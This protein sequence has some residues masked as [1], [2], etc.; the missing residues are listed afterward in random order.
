MTAAS[1]AAERAARDSYG[2]LLAWLAARG[3]DIAAAEDALAD[4]FAAALATWPRDG[5]PDKPEA[6]LLTA[7]RR[8]LLDGHRRR[9]TAT[10]AEPTLRHTAL[11]AEEA[12]AEAIPDH[13]L[14]LLL[15]CAAPEVERAAQA[16]LMLQVVL[17]LD[18]ARI[19]SAF[20]L[21]PTA[22]GQRLVRAKRRIAA[23]GARFALPG[24]EVVAAR[25]PAVLDAIYAAY[26]AGAQDPADGGALAGEALWLARIAAA[27]APEEAEAAGLA[28]LLLHL[29]ARRPAARD[30]A[31]RYVPLSAQD[32]GAWDTAMQA[33]AEAWLRRAFAL[34]APGRFQW[35]AAVQSV[36]A[37]RRVTGRTEWR[38]ILL[39]YDALM[40]ATGSP[41]VAVNRA[42]ALAEVEGAAAGLAAL[43]EAAADGRL[44]GYQ[45]FWAAMAALA[46]GEEAAAARQR[47]A[48]LA[49]DPAVR[50]FLLRLT[51][52]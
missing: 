10:A 45:P 1:L 12:D 15:A 41:V 49:T 50:D 3:R 25:L 17:G 39:L 24:R 20:L 23:S 21:S 26:A 33:E 14:A 6:W 34:G 36:H 30:A 35:E 40:A 52:S 8:R 43:R 19:A 48:G 16:P 38:E 47:A 4:A 29:E 9:A 46:G 42:V 11:L 5:V 13:R 22:M 44:A 37:A 31:G 7:A 51:P 18:A 28:A 32:M 27:L 2:R